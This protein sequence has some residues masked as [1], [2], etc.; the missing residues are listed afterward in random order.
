MSPYVDLLDCG[1]PLACSV[2]DPSASFCALA[3]RQEVITKSLEL[4]HAELAVHKKKLVEY[5]TQLVDLSNAADK[6]RFRLP[7]CFT[8]D[9]LPQGNAALIR[10]CCCTDLRL[11][12]VIG[13]MLKPRSCCAQV[14]NTL[15]KTSCRR[16]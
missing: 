12:C 6:A 7:D 9:C 4:A 14:T 1:L 3:E 10:I 13:Q 8:M 11:V 15:Q 2:I 16:S 5:Q